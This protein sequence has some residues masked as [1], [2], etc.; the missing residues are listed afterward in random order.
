MM[1]VG[2]HVNAEHWFTFQ[3]DNYQY[4]IK[5]LFMKFLLIKYCF[6]FKA[7]C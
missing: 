2:V 6:A 3:E 1:R 5:L 4:F 7:H